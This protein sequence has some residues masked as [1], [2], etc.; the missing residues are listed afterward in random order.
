MLRACFVAFLVLMV[1]RTASAGRAPPKAPNLPEGVSVARDN[2][3]AYPR[4][5]LTRVF[6]QFW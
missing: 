4:L 5:T 1:T 2:R 6:I 3:L